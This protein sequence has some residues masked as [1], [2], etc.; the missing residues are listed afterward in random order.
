[1]SSNPGPG[2]APA[3]VAT[4]AKKLDLEDGLAFRSVIDEITLAET[5][6]RYFPDHRQRVFSP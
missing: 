2:I 1:M 5:T 3:Q 4:V 6:T